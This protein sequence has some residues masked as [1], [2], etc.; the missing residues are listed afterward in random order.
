MQVARSG[1]T[2]VARSYGAGSAPGSEMC[3]TKRKGSR[4]DDAQEATRSSKS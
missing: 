1:E 2:G 4:Y 3:I